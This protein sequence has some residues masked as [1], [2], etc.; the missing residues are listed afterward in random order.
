MNNTKHYQYPLLLNTKYKSNRG[1]QSI[2]TLKG[3]K[4]NR[5]HITAILRKLISQ[6]Y[7][8]LPLDNA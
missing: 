5:Q 6:Y 3:H 7:Y 1:K 2:A 4:S 8:L